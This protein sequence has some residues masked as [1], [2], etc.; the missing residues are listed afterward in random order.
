MKLAGVLWNF[1]GLMLALALYIFGL[2][3]LKGVTLTIMWNW[4]VKPLGAPGLNVWWALGLMAMVGLAAFR[5]NDPD[6]LEVRKAK[7]PGEIIGVMVSQL[8]AIVVAC[9]LTLLFGAV[10]HSLM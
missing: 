7:T 9:A 2:A 6:G 8:W 3:L 1:F 10:Y 5:K 4:F